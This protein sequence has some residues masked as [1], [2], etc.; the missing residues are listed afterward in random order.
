M[1]ESIT[2]A[3]IDF[4]TKR[5]EKLTMKTAR[6]ACECECESA[7]PDLDEVYEIPACWKNRDEL[8]IDGNPPKSWCAECRTREKLHS[9]LPH[10]TRMAG[11]ALRTLERA[12]KKETGNP[13]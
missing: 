5:R 13:A 2:K 9:G 8:D 1:T 3:A 11:A 10:A 12:V 7:L 6:N 4:I